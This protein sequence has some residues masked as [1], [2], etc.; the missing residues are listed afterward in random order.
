[1]KSLYLPGGENAAFEVQFTEKP[2]S[3]T[4]LKDNKPLDD[5]LADRIITREIGATTFRL[6]IK[7]CR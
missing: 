7:H 2:G 1:M 4:W 5:R 6:E 3:V